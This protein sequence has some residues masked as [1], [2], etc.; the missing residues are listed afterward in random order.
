[1]KPRLLAEMNCDCWAD[2]DP[3]SEL[4]MSG[5]V[6][7]AASSQRR[8][9]SIACSTGSSHGWYRSRSR[10]SVASRDLSGRPAQSSSAVKRAID[11]A[12]STE[13]RSASREKSLE[14]A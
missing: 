2:T 4:R 11:S 1:M 6:A 8:A 9:I 14:L 13:A 10:N 5:E 7:K 12:A 3:P